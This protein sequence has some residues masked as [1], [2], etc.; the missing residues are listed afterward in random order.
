MQSKNIQ[1]YGVISQ[2][3]LWEDYKL[4]LAGYHGVTRKYVRYGSFMESIS[5]HGGLVHVAIFIYWLT[6]DDI[7]TLIGNSPK[8]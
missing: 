5:A 6:S 1:E 7:H 8:L 2:K 3:T 4:Q